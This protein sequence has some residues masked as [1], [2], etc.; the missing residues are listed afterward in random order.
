MSHN[1]HISDTGLVHSTSIFSSATVTESM[2][3]TVVDLSRLPSHYNPRGHIAVGPTGVTHGP[4]ASLGLNE[5]HP[6]SCTYQHFSDQ[7]A[8]TICKM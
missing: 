4:P 6:I 1:S 2:S 5:S 8:T 3:S 7:N